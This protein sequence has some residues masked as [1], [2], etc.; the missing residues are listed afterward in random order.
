MMRLVGDKVGEHVANIEREVAPHVGFRRRHL[1]TRVETKHKQRFDA[2]T[3]AFESR[4]E[5]LT[6]HAGEVDERWRRDSMLTAERPDPP[7]P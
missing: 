7:A 2:A 3:T 1:T 4:K 5:L 6:C